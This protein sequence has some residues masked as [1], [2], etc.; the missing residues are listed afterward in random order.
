[1]STH[2]MFLWRNKQ[3]YPLII[4]KY[5]QK[6]LTE[7]QA[8]QKQLISKTPAD[9]IGAK[10]FLCLLYL[11]IRALNTIF[12]RIFAHVRLKPAWSATETS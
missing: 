5:P 10:Y 8:V 6:F 12:F 3:N 2:N 7:W 11:F 1:M 9:T 4:T